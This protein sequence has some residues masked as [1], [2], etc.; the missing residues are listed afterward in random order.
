M[1]LES[2]PNNADTETPAGAAGAGATNEES[3]GARDSGLGWLEFTGD[4]ILND[5]C[6]QC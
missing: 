2:S 1:L 6:T 4:S 5:T 3:D